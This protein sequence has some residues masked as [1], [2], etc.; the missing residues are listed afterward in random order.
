M[1]IDATWAI[2]AQWRRERERALSQT[3]A[4]EMIGPTPG[5]VISRLHAASRSASPAISVDRLSMRSS[6][7]CQSPASYSMT[8]AIRG[9]RVSVRVAGILASSPRLA[10][11]NAALQQEGADPI[12][13]AGALADQPLTHP[14]QRAF[15][16][17][18]S[19]VLERQG[20]NGEVRM[21][22]LM[23]RCPE[24][25]RGIHTQYE[26]TPARFLSMPV[27]FSRSYCSICRTEHEWFARD[28]WVYEHAGIR[29]GKHND[30][31]PGSSGHD[32]EVSMDRR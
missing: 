2:G 15:K 4:L 20:T 11:C 25:G 9:D 21:G 29:N 32:H 18:C 6:S 30:S 24:T 23:I 7:R 17:S 26:V 10:D 5:T 8:R 13:D 19:T 16:S 28:A 1:P 12:D 31:S 27:F 3:I 22:V 14:V